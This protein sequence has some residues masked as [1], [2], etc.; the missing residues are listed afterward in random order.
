[1]ELKDFASFDNMLTPTIIKILFWL[2]V[3]LSMLFGLVMIFQGLTS[4]FGGG[5]TVFIG[6]LWLVL[7]PVATRIYCELLIVIFK[8]HENL[9]GIRASLQKEAAP[10]GE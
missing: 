1:M 4:S 10:V 7:G 6:L 2:G 5:V 9:V 8:I 3:V